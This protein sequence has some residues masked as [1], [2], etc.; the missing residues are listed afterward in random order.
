[1]KKK[2]ANLIKIVV[3][4]ILIIYLINKVGLSNITKTMININLVYLPLILLLWIG[5]LLIGAINIKIMLKALNEKLIFTKTLKHYLRSWA[6]GLFL[7]GKI[8]EFS[9]IYFLKKENIELSK[10]TIIAFTD[11]IITF[12]VLFIIAFFGLINI[13]NLNDIISILVLIF[14]VFGLAFFFLVTEKGRDLIKKYVLKRYSKKFKNFFKNFSYL[15]KKR[16]LFLLLNTFFTL[17]KWFLIFII[18][19]LLFKSIDYHINFMILISA[20]SI[21][22]IISLIPISISGLGVRENSS[23]AVFVYYNVPPIIAGS[24]LLIQTLIRYIIGV[25]VL[26]T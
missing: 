11:K 6:Y 8:G 17:L 1:M 14:L 24:V 21:G 4:F 20:I 23:L 5:N 16:T 25:V 26:I 18:I 9:L 15:L 12:F 22:L 10:G 7:P 3:S 19:Y 2:V 13:L